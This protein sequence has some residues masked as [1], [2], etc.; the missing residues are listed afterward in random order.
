MVLLKHDL[1]VFCLRRS[2]VWDTL[3]HTLL[4]LNLWVIILIV[5]S[6]IKIRNK[7]QFKTLYLRLMVLLAVVISLAFRVHDYIYFYILFEASLIPTFM[8]I[9]GW[10]YQPERLQAGVYM[11]MYTV[12]ASL[13]LLVSLLFLNYT[14]NSSRI[15]I[16]PA[17][18]SFTAIAKS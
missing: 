11:L 10:G 6:R 14:L 18:I 17:I 9:L 15:I 16:V 13:P 8:L 3:S 7:H 4:V 12:L 5:F 1:D 2:F